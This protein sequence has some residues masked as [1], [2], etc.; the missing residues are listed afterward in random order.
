MNSGPLVHVHVDGRII[1]WIANLM[2]SEPYKMNNDSISIAK[3]LAQ[4]AL[5]LKVKPCSGTIIHV[6]PWLSHMY[7]HIYKKQPPPPKKKQQNTNKQK[8]AL[9]ALFNNVSTVKISELHGPTCYQCLWQG[10]KMKPWKNCASKEW[11]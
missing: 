10:V 4:S 1:L 11:K 7:V 8:Q 5:V 9:K 6:S 2:N 3:F